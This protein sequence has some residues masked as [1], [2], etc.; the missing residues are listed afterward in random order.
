MNKKAFTL[1]EVMI[2]CGVLAL[3][4][5]GVMGLYSSGSKMS[6]ST[7]WL[8]HIT[9]QLKTAARA[10]NASIRKSS[11]PSV[12]SFPSEIIQAENDCFRVRFADVDSSRPNKFLVITESIPG[13]KMNGSGS[14]VSANLTYHVYS[15][16]ANGDLVYTKYKDVV[17]AS[18]IN[19]GFSRT[20]PGA[21]TQFYRSVLVK[22]VDSVKCSK[23]DSTRDDSP[24]KVVI[25]CKMPRA[26]TTRSETVIG[27][28]NVKVGGTP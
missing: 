20:I 18:S 19:T 8:Q 6:N 7:I 17:R 3:F 12:V 15:L 11:Y 9:T 24:V 22:D 10:I 1:I 26:N 4:M 23:T 28:P 2:A 13:K 25:N 16:E 21:G 27:T 5:G 14:D